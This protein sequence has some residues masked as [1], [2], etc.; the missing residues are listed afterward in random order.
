MGPI[1]EGLLENEESLGVQRV[2]GSSKG[3][4]ERSKDLTFTEWFRF[5]RACKLLS[6]VQRPALAQQHSVQSGVELR[7]GESL[8]CGV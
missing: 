8:Q 3:H 5:P 7:R 2:D 6:L 1:R 4:L